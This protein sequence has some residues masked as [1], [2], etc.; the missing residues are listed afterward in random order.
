MAT[1]NGSVTNNTSKY[2]VYLEVTESDVSIP[3][4][5]SKVTVK[6]H[7]T[8]SYWGWIAGSAQSGSI[9]IDG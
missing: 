1:Y 7:I 3:N 9:I 6:L 8:R 5:T 2:G 4:N